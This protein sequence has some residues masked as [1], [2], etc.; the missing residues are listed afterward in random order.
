MKTKSID[1]I[2]AGIGGL[3]TAIALSQKEIQIRIFEQAKAFKT[4]GAGIILANNAMQ[5]FEKLGLREEI[6]SCGNPI[7]AMHIT[8]ASLKPISSID[9][10]YFERKHKVQN[11]AI[12]RGKLQDILLNHLDKKIIK[13]GYELSSVEE[14]PTGFKLR[15]NNGE[16]TYSDYLLGADGL[17]SVVRN[18]LFAENK[19]R[20]A[21]QVCWRGVT[22]FELPEQY[23][24]ELNE[25]W[26]KGD[27][28]GFVQI[29]PQ[30]VYW[31]A[32]KT[33]KTEKSDYAMERLAEYFKS[34]H[35]IIR[36]I[37]ETT[38][39]YKIHAAEIS[40]LSPIKNWYKGK[41]CLLGDAA[42]ATTPNMGQGACQAIEDA[43][44]LSE[45]MQQYEWDEAFAKYQKLRK[46]KAHEVVK[47][48]WTLGKIAHWENPL[49]IFMRNQLMKMTPKRLNRKQSERIFQLDFL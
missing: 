38:P 9:L 34:Y 36:N 43:Y 31:Y 8:R 13:T 26:G 35:P 5:V 23:Q 20:N 41:V 24:N 30:K 37:I 11:I 42:H 15:F 48:S 2:G 17:N 21:F 22:D 46:P 32:L 6:A 47:T 40:D 49:A 4:V 29:A 19:T 18:S 10:S 28:F 3:T 39:F 12:H 1:I 7:S 45:C 44:V 33:L 25:A 14:N 16:S 27:R